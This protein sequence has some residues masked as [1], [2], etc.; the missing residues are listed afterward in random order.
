MIRFLLLVAVLASCSCGSFSSP[1]ENFK[2]H[3]SH[4]INKRIDDPNT[5]WVRPEYLIGARMLANGNIENQYQWR[6]SCMYFFEFEVNT[7][8]I[9]S[10]RFEGSEK[11]CQIAP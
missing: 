10:W 6:G 2:S 3:M 4:N 5:N 11:D 1:H 7:K 9:V 8:K